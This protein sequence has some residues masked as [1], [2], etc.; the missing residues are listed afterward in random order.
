VNVI[1]GEMDKF[2]D[3]KMAGVQEPEAVFIASWSAGTYAPIR[4]KSKK[5]V[6]YITLI[7]KQASSF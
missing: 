6:L 1:D 5:L 4:K 7:Q 2:E 3:L